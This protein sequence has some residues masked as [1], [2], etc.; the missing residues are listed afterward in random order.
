MVR[1]M[2]TRYMTEKGIST[3]LTTVGQ[4]QQYHDLYQI[5]SRHIRSKI[6]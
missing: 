3:T 5:I 4:Q 1:S 2:Y 6:E